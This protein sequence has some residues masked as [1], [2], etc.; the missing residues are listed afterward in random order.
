MAAPRA[1]T[2]PKPEDV[3]DAGSVV[4]PRRPPTSNVPKPVP[5]PTRKEISPGAAGHAG[6]GMKSAMGM[7]AVGSAVSPRGRPKGGP[8]PAAASAPTPTPRPARKAKPSGS[9]ASAP[10]PMSR[11]KSGGPTSR[12]RQ[13]QAA[14]GAQ[15]KADKKQR[16]IERSKKWLA[17]YGGSSTFGGRSTD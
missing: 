13:A 9:V 15:K 7:E 16:Q 4:S 10:E 11:P 5:R 14:A 2:P 3:E 12:P 6:A 8:S 17:R 1:Y